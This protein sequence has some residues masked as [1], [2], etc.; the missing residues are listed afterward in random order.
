MEHAHAHDAPAAPAATRTVKD[1]VCGMQVDPEKAE[2][3]TTH[4][5]V[6]YAFCSRGCRARFVQDP[7][8]YLRPQTP[9]QGVAAGVYT[10]PMHPEVE[11]EGPG[12]C[13]ACGMALE[14]NVIRAPQTKTQYTC[15]MHPEVIQDEPGSCPKCGMA[16]EPI[17]VTEDE[18]PDP[19]LLDMTRRFWVSFAL[20]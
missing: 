4:E 18:E 20:T 5:G 1:P 6:A 10:C 8:A 11:Q 9:A 13:P 16:L 15:P 2:H 19:E 14:P 7:D 3:R 12:V 17:T